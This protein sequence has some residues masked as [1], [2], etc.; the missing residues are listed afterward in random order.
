MPISNINL[1]QLGMKR[2][3][4]RV[5]LGNHIIAVYINNDEKFNEAFAFLKDGLQRNE[6]IVITTTDLSKDEIR[7]RMRNEWKVDVTELESRDDI[8]IRTT[9]ELY[10]PDGIPNIHRT[11]TLLSTLA[12]NCLSKGKRGIRVFG[13]MTAFFKKGFTKELFDYESCLE[14]RFNFPAIGTCAYDSKDIDNNMTLEQI[15]QLQ[16][17]H[18]QVWMENYQ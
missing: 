11:I 10:F 16:Q 14:Q 9:E 2:M 7:A 6:V 13:D 18:N 4:Q 5:E 17:Y 8:I 12:E 15:R 3:L 1:Y